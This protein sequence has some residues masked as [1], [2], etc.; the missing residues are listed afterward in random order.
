MKNNTTV[1]KNKC[2]IIVF[3]LLSLCFYAQKTQIVNDI[4]AA[5]HF[6]NHYQKKKYLKRTRKEYPSLI[7]CTFATRKEFTLTCTFGNASEEK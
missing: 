4:K 2:M 7:S 1:V 6:K 5:E 3:I